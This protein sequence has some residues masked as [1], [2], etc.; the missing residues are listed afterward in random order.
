MVLL[1][2]NELR[3]RRRRQ[4]TTTSI[5]MWNIFVVF[6][7]IRWLVLVF[8]IWIY[9][10]YLLL[11][12]CT[13]ISNR[14]KCAMFEMCWC[15]VNFFFDSFFSVEFHQWSTILRNN[16]LYQKWFSYLTWNKCVCVCVVFLYS[17][18]AISSARVKWIL[19]FQCIFVVYWT[20]D[21]KE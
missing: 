14:V 13:T 10:Y 12:F 18:G 11:Q 16:W 19:S 17:F 4:R 7:F 3:R 8:Q 21:N 5:T 9:F 20:K 1:H 6:L 15:R 2:W